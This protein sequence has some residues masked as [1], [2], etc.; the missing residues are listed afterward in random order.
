MASSRLPPSLDLG[1]AT[2]THA[3]VSWRASVSLLAL[4][5]SFGPLF[6]ATFSPAPVPPRILSHRLSPLPL[7]PLPRVEDDRSILLL[8]VSSPSSPRRTFAG[9]VSLGESQSSRLS[10][11]TKTRPPPRSLPSARQA[12]ARRAGPPAVGTGSLQPAAGSLSPRHPTAGSAPPVPTPATAAAAASVPVGPVATAALPVPNSLPA[13]P[14]SLSRGLAGSEPGPAGL[15]EPSH[16]VPRRA[17]SPKEVLLP[18]PR[19]PAGLRGASKQI[20]ALP[21]AAPARKSAR[22]RPARRAAGW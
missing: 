8:T 16:R 20:L 13:P 22:R 1:R 17:D 19:A 2:Q 3:L 11:D 14:I 7:H 15:P 12:A 21:L 18:L 10:R 9:A 6:R 4:S 5:T